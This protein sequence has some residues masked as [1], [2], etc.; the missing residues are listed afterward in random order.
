MCPVHVLASLI[1]TTAV[2]EP[3]FPGLHGQQALAVLRRRLA[4]IRADQRATYR[5]HDFRR[6]HAQDLLERGRGLTA[7]LRA[8]D[9][10][11]CALMAYLDTADVQAR[12]VLEAAVSAESDSDGG[13]W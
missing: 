2:G 8:G 10:R 6:G 9:W 13:E 7:I 12:A 5:L 4:L 11:S 1:S 3:L